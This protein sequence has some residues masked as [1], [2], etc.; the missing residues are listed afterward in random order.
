MVGI[1]M[2]TYNWVEKTKKA[3]QS[4]IEHTRYPFKFLIIDNHSTDG[5]DQ[6]ARENNIRYEQDTS[7][8]NLARALN[9]AIRYFVDDREIEYVCWIHNDMLFFDNWLK[10]L[11]DFA[12]RRP[13]A[14]KIHPTN[15][16]YIEAEYKSVWKDP[17]QIDGA[18]FEGI[19]L[20][21]FYNARSS[22]T[23]RFMDINFYNFEQGNE[24]PWII[25]KSVF[26]KEN[27]WFDEDYQGIA[28]YEDWDFNNQLLTH[29]FDVLIYQGSLIWHPLKG[30]RA[31]LPSRQQEEHNRMNEERYKKKWSGF[32]GKNLWLVGRGK[33]NYYLKR[34]YDPLS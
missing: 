14:G 17:A 27:I 5:T 4:L 22:E 6:F 1:F 34:I 30:T 28:N 7:G 31:K 12:K 10:N 11:V 32:W 13:K 15:W 21:K 23:A 9:Q 25:P 33:A 18:E 26:Q 16:F 2:T 19:D 24:C 20:D 29:G 3:F 8:N